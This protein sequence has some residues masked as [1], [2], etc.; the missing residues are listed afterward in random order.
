M[1]TVEEIG[2]REGIR[3]VMDE[4]GAKA[5]SEVIKSVKVLQAVKEI[6]MHAEGRPLVLVF[7]SKQDREMREKKEQEESAKI[8]AAL[9]ARRLTEATS[10]AIQKA[11]ATNA[12]A[13]VA[14]S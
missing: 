3:L 5:L 2:Y 6:R 14:R 13:T 10:S 11:E 9:E 1:I 8:E 12:E 7:E 4:E